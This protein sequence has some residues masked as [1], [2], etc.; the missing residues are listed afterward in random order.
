MTLLSLQR[1]PPLL[2]QRPPLVIAAPAPGA[3]SVRER[4]ATNRSISSVCVIWKI[5]CTWGRAWDDHELDAAGVTRSVDVENTVQPAR[6]HE[7]H[8][9]QVE[10][11]PASAAKQAAQERLESTDAARIDLAEG[12]HDDRV[13]VPFELGVHGLAVLVAGGHDGC[14]TRR[15]KRP[16]TRFWGVSGSCST[17]RLKRPPARFWGVSG[18]CSIPRLKR[19]VPGWYVRCSVSVVIFMLLRR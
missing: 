7:A 10:H 19:G 6:V 12:H 1:M 11:E 13:A 9:A 4:T 8:I 16:T 14:S 5:R 15:L 3:A 18:S 2:G 17:P